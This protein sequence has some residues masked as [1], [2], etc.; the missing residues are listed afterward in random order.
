MKDDLACSF[1]EVDLHEKSKTMNV[2]LLFL[3]LKLDT[4]ESTANK[5]THL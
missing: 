1:F 4:K 3:K 5:R 2:C